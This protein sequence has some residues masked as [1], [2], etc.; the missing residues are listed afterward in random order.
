MATNGFLAAGATGLYYILD[1]D[2][3]D[4][5]TA[6]AF[7]TISDATNDTAYFQVLDVDPY[8]N[9]IA[10]QNIATNGATSYW[11]AG[12]A[13][14]LVGPRGFT[15]TTGYSG[16]TGVQGPTGAGS[17]WTDDGNSNISYTSGTTKVSTLYVDTVNYNRL[18]MG[19]LSQTKIGPTGENSI[20][21]AT[22]FPTNTSGN[23]IA[24]TT[25]DVIGVTGARKIRTHINLNIEDVTASTNNNLY[26]S[27]YDGST[28]INYYTHAYRSGNLCTSLNFYDY[29]S[30]AT[31]TS[32]TY[33]LYGTSTTTSAAIS[34]NTGTYSA[35]GAPSSY[36]TI[37]DIGLS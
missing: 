14:V 15:G 8:N 1:S 2:N 4:V 20:T 19:M 5:I 12:A 34:T 27:L 26:F 23:L 9:Q 35:G 36:I 22:S 16:P 11:S 25:F 29:S 31:D 3:N 32:K 37:E 7:I 33:H 6:N 28:L 17:Q 24:S 18:P 10:I 30:V 21:N 13:L